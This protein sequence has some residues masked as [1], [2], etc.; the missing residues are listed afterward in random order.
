MPTLYTAPAS[1]QS[2]PVEGMF[3]ALKARDLSSIL[4]AQDH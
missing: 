4:S 1:F 3:A 2:L